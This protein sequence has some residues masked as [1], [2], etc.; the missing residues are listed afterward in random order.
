M[1]L[2][3]SLSYVP[4]FFTTDCFWKVGIISHL[5]VISFNQDLKIFTNQ[6]QRLHTVFL[7]FHEKFTWKENIYFPSLVTLEREFL[8]YICRK[9]ILF[10]LVA[11][12]LPKIQCKKFM[13]F[14]AKLWKKNCV[15][16]AMSWSNLI[17][18]EK[19]E[20]L[21]KRKFWQNFVLKIKPSHRTLN[22]KFN[23]N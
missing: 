10:K 20:N 23:G 4:L 21:K 5:N 17:A 9:N 15:L 18:S 11:E 22:P 19:K 13:I 2:P 14:Y 8:L 7:M 6:F 16:A 12:L 3:G 1:I